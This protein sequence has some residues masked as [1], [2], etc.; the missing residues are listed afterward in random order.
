MFFAFV[1]TYIHTCPSKI[2]VP[3]VVLHNHELF[4]PFA[5]DS[6]SNVCYITYT[7]I[8]TYI[9]IHTY[10]HTYMHIHTYIHFVTCA[11]LYV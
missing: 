5:D 3:I 7:Y 6:D 10:M 4:H 9:H 2:I 1:H 8:H 11:F